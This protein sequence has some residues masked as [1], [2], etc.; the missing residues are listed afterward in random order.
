MSKTPQNKGEG[1]GMSPE[2]IRELIDKGSGDA[3][4][5]QI[6]FEELLD[7]QA[8]EFADAKPIEVD[9]LTDDELAEMKKDEAEINQ[10]LKRKARY[11][12]ARLS[13]RLGMNLKANDPES[14]LF[15]TAEELLLIVDKVETDPSSV[16]ELELRKYKTSKTIYDALLDA[17]IRKR[18]KEKP[19]T[20]ESK[21][22]DVDIP[23]EFRTS[24]M[25]QT[26]LATLYKGDITQK[27]IKAMIESGTLRTVK[28]SRQ[29]FIFDKR[30]LPEH[31]KETL[32]TLEQS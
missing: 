32:R 14:K 22:D 18:S 17:E 1:N 26:E 5:N 27:K 13:L 19:N 21:L 11:D 4:L 10:Q 12:K 23:G 30:Q 24:P 7:E 15:K 2:K 6:V 8:Q 3:D 9:E 31:V 16:S 28:Q 29:K 20:E 25:S